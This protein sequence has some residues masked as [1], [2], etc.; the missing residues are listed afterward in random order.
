[1][2]TSFSTLFDNV[3]AAPF[4]PV[5]LRG[6][7]KCR[8]TSGELI[9]REDM[10]GLYL[11]P[12]E[13]RKIF[14]RSVFCLPN[15]CGTSLRC[16]YMPRLFPHPREYTGNKSWQ[17]IY[18]LVRNPRAHKIKSALPPPRIRV[19]QV[20]FGKLA[21]LQQDGAFFG[22]KNAHF[23]PFPPP[24][25]KKPRYPPL[26]TRNFMGMEFLGEST[27]LSRRP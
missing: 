5:L 27:H 26:A 22:P 1:M 8:K 11:H 2:S 18:V 20:R 25:K 9:L 14:L 24:P 16:A 7:D 3:C 21:F 13:H 10:R 15:S 23:R 17:V 19:K 4:F 12:R 6:S